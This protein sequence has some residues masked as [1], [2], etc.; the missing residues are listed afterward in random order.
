MA[1]PMVA[2]RH[3]LE[4][5]VGSAIAPE[6][7]AERGYY[8][9]E[10]ADYVP[11]AFADY[12]R[13]PGLVIPIRDTTGEIAT[14]QLKA[15]HPRVKDGKPIKYETATNGRLCID[16]P[17]QALPLLRE[18][19]VPLWITEGAKKVDSAL[20]NGIPCVIGLLG[21]WNW[22]SKGVA[23]PDWRDIALRGRSVTIAYDSDV[24]TK[25]GPR[26]AIKELSTWL[27]TRGATID[28][29]M[30]PERLNDP[31]AA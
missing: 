27:I 21:V 24:M 30:L 11:A 12:Q 19:D 3:R 17:R 23:L 31:E 2:D 4:L 10:N 25:D 22:L 6:V 9:A 29:L 20:S 8:T 5:E 28:N 15:D 18:P 7:I 14:Y 26:R 16:V 13:R 1:M